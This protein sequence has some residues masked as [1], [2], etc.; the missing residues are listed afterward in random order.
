[1]IRLAPANAGVLRL[2][3]ASLDAM[4]KVLAGLI[5]RAFDFSVALIGLIVL[6]P[7]F[8]LIA[9]LIKRDSPGPVFYWG[10]RVGR[11][12]RP[13]R[14][15]KFRTMYERAAS[16]LGP[17]VTC[18]DDGRITP[19]GGWLRETKLNELPQLW[20]VLIGEMSLVGPRP[21]DPEIAKGWPEDVR[22]EV[23]SVKP[24]I[25][26]PASILY[27][28]EEAILSEADVIGD[29]CRNI[30]P[31]KMRLD[32]L[33]VRNHSFSSDLD[34][35]FWTAVILIP[36]IGKAKIP[37]GYLFAGPFSRLVNRYI[38]WFL[39]DLMVSLGAAGTAVLLWRSQGPLNWGIMQLTGLSIVL[40]LLFSGI[41]AIA[42]LNRIVWTQATTEDAAGLVLSSG[43]VTLSF[44]LLDHV[45]SYFDWPSY[46]PLP[47]TM[48]FT[49]GLMASVGFVVLR[50]RLRLVTGLASRWLRWRRNT[51]GV[52][53]RVLIVGAGEGSRI[54]NWLLR[55]GESRWPFSVV[56]IVDDD[57]PTQ[58]GMR[59]D[60]CWVLGGS[61]DIPELIKRHDIGVVL[62]AI[63]HISLE[64]KEHIANLC[65]RSGACLVFLPDL[66]A[67]LSKQLAQ[68][69][70]ARGAFVALDT[71]EV[72]GQYANVLAE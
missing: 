58:H 67:A 15:L 8:V 48:I 39:A 28:D 41:N 18:K 71:I 4:W 40:A 7:V 11:R 66:L 68:P 61:A 17:R 72:S 57:Q 6:L 23:L 22:Q 65:E 5:K 14:I 26:S 56:G 42:G 33:Y 53:E 21:E 54:A 32:R 35:I 44:M 49:I 24:G 2:D 25:T 63:P 16:Y 19:F 10:P 69:L 46:P 3:Q 27:H 12:E 47:K 64:R 36:R 59:V 45:R 60:G 62:L 37:E 55:H 51:M 50:Y 70:K 31:D 29:Y 52:G 30:V 13:F 20:N 34:T 9:I 38:S 1:M 43:L